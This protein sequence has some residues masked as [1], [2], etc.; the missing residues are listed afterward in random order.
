MARLTGAAGAVGAAAG[1]DNGVQT[2]VMLERLQA[3]PW[4]RVDVS[5]R[6]TSMPFF[7]HNLIQACL[8]T[9][10]CLCSTP[11]E[12]MQLEGTSKCSVYLS[13]CSFRLYPCRAHPALTKHDGLLG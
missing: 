7:A 5:F 8:I 10:R 13:P 11:P 12:H 4:R 2:T 6:G 9:R 1:G 3:L